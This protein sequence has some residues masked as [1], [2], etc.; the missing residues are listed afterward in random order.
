ME[1]IDFA[2]SFLFR[3]FD[4][5][6][7]DAELTG[8][9][10]ACIDLQKRL[11]P[12][13]LK[14]LFRPNARAAEEVSV[15]KLDEI[16]AAKEDVESIGL[17]AKTRG[18]IANC[19]LFGK[20]VEGA[21]RNT[22]VSRR[23]RRVDDL[24]ARKVRE[25]FRSDVPVWADRIGHFWYP[26]GSYM[27]WHTN[28]NAPGWRMYVTHCDEPGKSFFRYR[29]PRSHEI[30]TS[31]D[32]RWTVRLFKVAADDLM[33]HTVYSDT[34]RYSFGYR[35]V[36]KPSLTHRITN[37]LGR[38]GRDVLAGRIPRLRDI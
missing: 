38:V 11:E 15:E 23:M 37:K 34:N 5:W 36:E 33:W 27:G 29:N 20:G 21:I 2:S 35:I 18:R 17:E 4:S 16:L 14:S 12:D 24:V 9:L 8:R 31:Y 30:V 1:Q 6:A 19:I 3:E 10:G 7:E 26:P 13:L 25:L 22:E 32:R 28:S